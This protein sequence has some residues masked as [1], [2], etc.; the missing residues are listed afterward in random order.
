[1]YYF[2]INL[3]FTLKKMFAI[4]R[5]NGKQYHVN[6]GDTIRLDKIKSEPGSV[7]ETNEILAISEKKGDFVFGAPILKDAKIIGKILSHGK[8]K[9]VIVFK[10]KRRKTYRRKYGHRQT[11]TLVKIETINSK[12]SSIKNTKSDSTMTKKD[13]TKK[14]QSKRATTASTS[15]K[16][17]TNKNINK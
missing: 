1:M 2:N 16:K 10:R 9:K 5:K 4:F 13:E 11:H 8:D 12:A 3:K 7:F 17:T 14:S 15:I 6:E